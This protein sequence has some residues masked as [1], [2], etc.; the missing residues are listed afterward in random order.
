MRMMCPCVLLALAPT[1]AAAANLEMV[2]EAKLGAGTGRMEAAVC[3]DGEMVVS[4]GQGRLLGLDTSSGRV[5]WEQQYAELA[6]ATSLACDDGRVIAGSRLENQVRILKRAVGAPPVLK[7]SYSVSVRVVRVATAPDGGYWLFA[8]SP[9]GAEVHKMTPA[10]K[11]SS[12][13]RLGEV[14][15]NIPEF[16]PAAPVSSGKGMVVVSH[17]LYDIYKVELPE[18]TEASQPSGPG[19]VTVAARPSPG[20]TTQPL[21][22]QGDRVQAIVQL[23]DGRFVTHITTA[24]YVSADTLRAGQ[25]LE[26]LGTDFTLKHTGIANRRGQLRGADAAGALYFAGVGPQGIVVAKARLVE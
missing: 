21:G 7:A 8:L 2:W 11:I 25:M 6:Q 14:D 18:K 3:P 4:D 10:G 20:F 9:R 1:W 12:V 16:A 24:T 17:S 15:V 5:V 22:R 19:K 26:V 23:P 13:T